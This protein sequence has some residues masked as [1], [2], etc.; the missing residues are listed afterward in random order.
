MAHAAQNT[1]RFQT[2]LN[3]RLG[4]YLIDIRARF[5]RRKVYRDTLNELRA[6]SDREL[7]D[8]GINRANMRSIAYDAAYKM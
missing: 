7:M 8:L 4:T 1:T 2:G 6:L 3:D 5:A